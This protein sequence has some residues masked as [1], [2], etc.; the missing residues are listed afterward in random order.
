MIIDCPLKRKSAK[1]TA[2]I[3]D[4]PYNH[5][6]HLLYLYS[7]SLFCYYLILINKIILFCKK[8]FIKRQFTLIP[9]HTMGLHLQSVLLI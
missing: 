9:C 8:Y 2:N 7:F 1:M 5:S 4:L 3:N 6:Y